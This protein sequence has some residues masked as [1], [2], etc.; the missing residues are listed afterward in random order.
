MRNTHKTTVRHTRTQGLTKMATTHQLLCVFPSEFPTAVPPFKKRSLSR[1]YRLLRWIGYFS[2]RIKCVGL[3]PIFGSYD[4][5][6]NRAVLNIFGRSIGGNLGDQAVLKKTRFCSKSSGKIGKTVSLYQ[7]ASYPIHWNKKKLDIACFRKV[8][9]TIR[10]QRHFL[11]HGN[12][13]FE[14]IFPLSWISLFC[15]SHLNEQIVS[16]IGYCV[17]TVFLRYFLPCVMHVDVCG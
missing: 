13:Y 5:T 12:G 10:F 4:V 1:L 8:L 11:F 16:S 7:T 2:F 15:H 6:E 17:F 9:K 14:T 3:E